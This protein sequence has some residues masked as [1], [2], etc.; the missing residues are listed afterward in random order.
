MRVTFAF[1]LVFVTTVPAVCIAQDLQLGATVKAKA[2]LPLRESP[3]S[4]FFGQKGNEIGV[5]TP[6][7]PYIVLDT[8][9]FSTIGGGETWLKV[10]NKSD[11]SKSGWIFSGSKTDPL[12]NITMAR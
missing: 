7:N 10:I 8:K 12:A 11:P 5:V 3:P 2:D 9:T 4:G 1:I 6:A